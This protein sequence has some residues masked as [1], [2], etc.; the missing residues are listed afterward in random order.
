MA[1]RWKVLLLVSVG[2]FMASLDLFIVN[3]AFPDLSRSFDDASLPSLSWVLNAYAIVF[4]A[5]LVPAGRIADRVGRKRVFLSGLVVF[6]LASGLCAASP[7]VTA[8]IGARVL[9]AVGAAMMIPTTL[10]LIL[11]AFPPEQRAMAI[12]IWSA[13]SG[14]AAAL[15]PPLGGLL[16]QLSWHW[17]FLVNVPIGLGAAVIG[18][19]LLDEIR[20]PND[21]RPDLLG[22]AMLAVGIGLLTLG[23]VKGPEWGW[24]DPRDLATFAAAALLVAAFV[25]RSA[26]HRAPV[27]EL[28][29]LRVRSFAL[30]NLATLV[31]FGGFGAMLLSGVLLL[32]EVWGYSELRA[33]LALSPGP[34]MAAIFSIVSSRLGAR[35]GQRPVAAVGGLVFAAGFAFLLATVDASSSYA[36]TFLPGFLLGGAG[37]G[38]VMGTLPTAATAELPPSRYATGSAV[39]G[40]ARQLGS[41]I[42]VAVLVA[43]IA[44]ASDLLGGVRDGWWFALGAGLGTAVLAFA[45]GPV[46]AEAERR[47]PASAEPT[48]HRSPA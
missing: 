8:L 14:V 11:P 48:P 37:V 31:F 44:G 7:S 10:G 40:M 9:Q 26:H 29:L 1:H 38:L 41:A 16:V 18:A 27:I 3:I 24:S 33:G 39:F 5:L 35:I 23:I 43:L 13:V 20:E 2:L 42:G 30:A 22:A 45:I 46:G 36:S 25:Y 34:L 28:P 6:S 32:T 19:R 17:I 47:H 12:G 15:G 21:G 4:A